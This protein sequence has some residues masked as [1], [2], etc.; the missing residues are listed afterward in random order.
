MAKWID[1][2]M[3]ATSASNRYG[4]AARHF[5]RFESVGGDAGE[6]FVLCDAHALV[7]KVPA[8]RTLAQ[9]KPAPDWT[10]DECRREVRA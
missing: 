9:V 4:T 7:Q 10:C 5:Y 3:R 2:A 6:P 1:P 8:G